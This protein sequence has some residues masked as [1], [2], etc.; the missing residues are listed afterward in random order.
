MIRHV[1]APLI[2]VC[3]Q[4]YID[5]VIVYSNTYE[6]HLV[7]VKQA[8]E[9]IKEAGL[10][11]KMSKCEWC[12]PETEFLGFTVGSGKFKSIDTTRKKIEEWEVPTSVSKVRG[13]IG[14]VGWVR[15]FVPHF[16]DLALPLY[17]LLKKG[18]TFNWDDE[19]QKSFLGLKKAALD[20]IELKLF[21][22]GKPTR[23][24]VD[25]SKYAIG[26][27]LKQKNEQ[28]RW[29]LCAFFSKK[30]S[31]AKQNYSMGEQEFLGLIKAIKH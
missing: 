30:L 1:L 22:M 21:D 13:F 16:T 28:G 3:A 11:V 4:V 8:L 29:T 12:K 26:A 24:E 23:L 10:K 14:M 9:L 27:V 18:K 6:E 31:K 15:E 25:V 5:D 19:C 17:G 20:N 7:H 2:G